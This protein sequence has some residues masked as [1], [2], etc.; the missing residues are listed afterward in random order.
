MGKQGYLIDTNVAIEYIGETLPDRSL[1]ILDDIIDNEYSIS[2]I[3][4]IELLGY[5]DITDQEEEK[6]QQLI[7]AAIVFDLDNNV[8]KETI[9]LRKSYRI[10]L[11]DAIIAATAC[12]YDLVLITRDI[13]D[14]QKIN[15][16]KVI[17][18]E[19]L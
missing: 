7:R 19:G 11:P 15:A 6:F 8:V 13:K 4:R 2:V 5:A 9:K 18:P 14:F 1:S 3:N 17:S 10:K 16:L 12:L